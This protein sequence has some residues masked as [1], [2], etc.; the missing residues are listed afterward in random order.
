MGKKNNSMKNPASKITGFFKTEVGKITHPEQ[1]KPEL[2]LPVEINHTVPLN[3]EADGNVS[4]PPGVLAEIVTGLWRARQK[5]LVEDA[6]PSAE[7]RMVKRHL[8]AAWVALEQG[9]ISLVDYKGK[10]YNSGQSLNILAMQPVAGL[11][12]ETVIETIKP[13]ILYHN[14]FVQNGE[15][16][17]GMPFETE[18]E[19][20]NK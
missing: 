17:V 2:L 1:A 7:I 11:R 4:L 6:E 16:I 12:E 15:V 18:Q 3:P 13:T 14:R 8:D 9:G 19:E 20:E 5:L 10:A